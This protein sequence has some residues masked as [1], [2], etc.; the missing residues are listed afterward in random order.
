MGPWRNWSLENWTVYTGGQSARI[1]WWELI[2]DIVSQV[3]R[4]ISEGS[5]ALG[6]AKA[7][8]VCKLHDCICVDVIK[9]ALKTTL[10][11]LPLLS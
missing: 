2:C 3:Q 1:G 8:R 6:W 5:M 10:I 4:K 7:K 9:G 11:H